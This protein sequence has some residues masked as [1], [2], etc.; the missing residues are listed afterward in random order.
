MKPVTGLVC[1]TLFKEVALALATAFPILQR[2]LLPRM[3]ALSA[4]THALVKD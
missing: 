4:G 1:T 2:K 3:V